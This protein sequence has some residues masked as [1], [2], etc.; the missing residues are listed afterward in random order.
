MLGL[1]LVSLWGAEM[2]LY[3]EAVSLQKQT[4]K[5]ILLGV[6]R[7]G[8]HYCE[9]MGKNFFS[10]PEMLK[11]LDDKFIMAKVNISK[12]KLPLGL[13]VN[14]TPTFF[15][16]NTDLEVIKTIPGSWSKQDFKD[17]TEKIK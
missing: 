4:K 16:L 11:Y 15:I 6:V 7:T 13:K 14:F 9:D 5:K 3:T 12:E 1:G 2:Y 10:D 17:L 8:C